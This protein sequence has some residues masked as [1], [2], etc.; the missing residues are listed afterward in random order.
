MT[1]RTDLCE[2]V[3]KLPTHPTRF[4]FGDE[5]C[6]GVCEAKRLAPCEGGLGSRSEYA[7]LWIADEFFYPAYETHPRS[8]EGT[9]LMVKV[10]D[11]KGRGRVHLLAHRH[12]GELH[13]APFEGAMDGDVR[14][15][16]PPG[17]VSLQFTVYALN[18]TGKK[19][20]IPVGKPG[21]SK[22]ATDIFFRDIAIAEVHFELL[23][24]RAYM[25]VGAT[26]AEGVSVHPLGGDTSLGGLMDIRRSI[27][28]GAFRYSVIGEKDGIPDTGERLKY[29]DRLLLYMRLAGSDFIGFRGQSDSLSFSKN[30]ELSGS[31]SLGAMRLWKYFGFGADFQFGL[32][33][34]LLPIS[35][36]GGSPSE[37]ATVSSLGL[38]LNAVVQPGAGH[39]P[40]WLVAR[41]GVYFAETSMPYDGG[42][43]SKT[44][45][46]LGV[47]A[48]CLVAETMLLT[49]E[50]SR[51]VGMDHTI[52]TVSAGFGY[53]VRKAPSSFDPAR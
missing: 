41:T 48:W 19:W 5:S 37:K 27:E 28:D 39:W 11:A 42:S 50:V 21:L 2:Q 53:G 16:L 51:P 44:A 36:R 45:L 31:A 12:R 17:N 8:T 24:G 1:T 22:V 13:G 9:V 10:T 49:A 4:G 3:E 23:P 14:Y 30:H 25:L 18:S 15:E 20:A 38:D 6:R 26:P 7:T 43:Y 40:V 52:V 32:G 29:G 35:S 33:Q 47:A 46:N 34:P